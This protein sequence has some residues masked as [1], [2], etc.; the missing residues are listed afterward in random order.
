MTTIPDDLRAW[1]Q[2]RAQV[3][4]ENAALLRPEQQ[5]S[6]IADALLDAL[7]H[8]LIE[9]RGADKRVSFQ[10]ELLTHGEFVLPRPSEARALPTHPDDIAVDRFAVAMKAKLAQKRDEGRGGWENKLECS[11]EIL[12]DMLRDHTYKGDPVDVANFAMMLHQRGEGLT[13][14]TEWLLVSGPLLVPTGVWLHVWREGWRNTQIW[15]CRRWPDRTLEWIDGAGRTTVTSHAMPHPTHY[16]RIV[17]PKLP[18]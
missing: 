4:F 18:V 12:S 16:A 6:V 7:G 17:V 3:T 13:P 15:T 2:T 5:T 8:A 9:R 11:A 1:A 10:P 14:A